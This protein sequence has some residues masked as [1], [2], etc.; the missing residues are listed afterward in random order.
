MNQNFKISVIV[1]SYN[2]AKKLPNVLRALAQQTFSDFETVVVLDGSTDSSEQI[3]KENDFGLQNLRIITQANG[4][5]AVARNRGAKEATGDLLVFFDD[6]MRPIPE[7][8]A[9]HLGHHQNQPNTLLVGS[10]MEDQKVLKSD[11]QQF[12]AFLTH[13]WVKDL[14]QVTGLISPDR[15]FLMAAN[16]STPQSLFFQLAGFDPRLTDAEDFDLAVRATLKSISIY[17]NPAAMGWH[18]DF[19]TCRSYILRLRQY[20]KAQT[21]LKELKPE[22]YQ[23]FNQYDFKEIKGWKKSVYFIFAQSFWVKTIDGF[24]WLRILPQP[25]RYKVYDWITTGLSAYFPNKKI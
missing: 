3:L 20:Q 19:I 13:K 22:I 16:F 25:I 1:P 14:P 11:F 5:R 2:G 9:L 6:D 18:D 12:R 10:A 7:C 23:K 17:Y 4:G 8:V 24:N 15:P 21:R